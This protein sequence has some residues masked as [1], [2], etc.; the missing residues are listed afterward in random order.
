MISTVNVESIISR[1]RRKYGFAKL[2]HVKIEGD[3]IV[4]FINVSGVRARVY[5]Y[6]NGRIWVKSPIKNLSLSIKREFQSQRRRFRG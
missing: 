1:L 5:I 6:K 2:K 3:R 4:Y